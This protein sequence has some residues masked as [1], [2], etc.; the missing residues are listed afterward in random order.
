MR[1]D[2][3]GQIFLVTDLLYSHEK[4]GVAARFGLKPVVGPKDEKARVFLELNK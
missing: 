1:G 4:H 2:V 3:W